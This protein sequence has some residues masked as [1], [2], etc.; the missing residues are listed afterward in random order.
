M[1]LL[2]CVLIANWVK[3]GYTTEAM[4]LYATG[5]DQTLLALSLSGF[6]MFASLAVLFASLLG[7]YGMP[8]AIGCS[9]GLLLAYARADHV[10]DLR[11]SS[12]QV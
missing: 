2:V 10:R 4:R 1:P 5:R 7:A 12:V 11:S 3:V 8:L 9:Y 6:G